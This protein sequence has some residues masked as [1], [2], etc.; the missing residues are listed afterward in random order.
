MMDYT[1]AP[2]KE[3]NSA[4]PLV[5]H[6]RV[7]LEGQRIFSQGGWPFLTHNKDKV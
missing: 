6:V 3:G 5:S 7:L 4:S 2:K 1:C